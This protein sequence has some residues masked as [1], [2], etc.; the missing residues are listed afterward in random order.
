MQRKVT[1]K[2]LNSWYKE[3]RE[4]RPEI[5]CIV[6]A[7]KID[8]KCASCPQLS[9][10]VLGFTPV[11][12]ENQ[13]LLSVGSRGF[14][15]SPRAGSCA[16]LSCCLTGACPVSPAI[17]CADFIHFSFSSSSVLTT[18]PVLSIKSLKGIGVA[19]GQKWQ[20]REAKASVASPDQPCLTDH[21]FFVCLSRYEG[22]PEKLQFCP[23]VQFALLLCVCC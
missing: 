1:Y 8:G 9:R 21:V 6:V 10:V 20:Q 18:L 23:E 17:K 16:D 12:T 5:P 3:L 11:L 22:D 4:F 7:N 13:C 2:N 14:P 15:Q 19:P